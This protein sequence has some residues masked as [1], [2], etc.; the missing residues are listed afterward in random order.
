[1]VGKN[2]TAKDD[3]LQ[4]I[5]VEY[6]YHKL[7]HP[8]AVIESKIRQL[9]IIRQLDPKQYSFLKR[10][11]PYIVCGMLT[12]PIAERRILAIPNLL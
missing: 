11:L 12:L 2:V 3:A 8:D 7:I 6:L 10:Q 5:K 1:M 4:K 9:R